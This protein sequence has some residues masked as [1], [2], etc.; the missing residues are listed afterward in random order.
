MDIEEPQVL[1]SYPDDPIRW[2]HRVLL[3]RLQGSTWVVLT[4]DE[5][6]EVADLAEH[7]ILPLARD[8]PVPAVAA[9][10]TYL[11]AQLGEAP[12][13]AHHAAANRMAAVLGAPAAPV[14]D[15]GGSVASWR[16]ADTSAREFGTEVPADVVNAANTGVVRGSVGLARC[17]DPVRWLF[18]E[19]V[20][21]A[22][23][24]A[25]EADKHGGA[26]RDR[27]LGTNLPP[28]SAS[29]SLPLPEAVKGFRPKD[30][31]L[32]TGWP[33]KGPRAIM[34]VLASIITLGLTLFTYPAHWAHQA[35]IHPEAA[36]CW[37]HRMICHVLAMLT[38]FD[39]LDVSNCAGA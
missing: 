4:P 32:W 16:V 13:L 34:E 28:Q 18:V 5:E 23:P 36:L 22:E 29:A 11:F 14:A 37:G 24:E 12:L 19:R 10:N 20:P 9:G 8:A 39:R 2:H 17:G 35:G 33:H 38:C 1:I 27:R 6:V 30:L 21:N 25:W 3:R 15:P 7:Q 31:S 26:G